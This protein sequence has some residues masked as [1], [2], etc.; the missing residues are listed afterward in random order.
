M[1]SPV[2]GTVEIEG[3]EQ[4]HL[5]EVVRRDLA[6]RKDPRQVITDP[7]ARYYGIE[8]SERSLVPNDGA[9]LGQ[10]RFEDWLRSAAKQVPKTDL[11][12]A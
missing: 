1:G 10:T 3:P 11:Q 5:D 2:N 6:A 8:V 4:F 7:K 9:Q 12:P